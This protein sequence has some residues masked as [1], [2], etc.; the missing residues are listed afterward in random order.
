MEVGLNFTV[1]CR[2]ADTSFYSL[3]PTTE[4]IKFEALSTYSPSC[5]TAG[6]NLL[7]INSVNSYSTDL[8]EEEWG[9]T[10]DIDRPYSST[11]G[12]EAYNNDFPGKTT[13]SLWY[14][15]Q[16]WGNRAV[17]VIS[18][19]WYDASTAGVNDRYLITRQPSADALRDWTCNNLRFASK[20]GSGASAVLSFSWP[21][22][23][24]YF[25]YC[26]G[27]DI[28]INLVPC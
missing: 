1:S 21:F 2:E 16:R 6:L 4:D 7:S 23:D 11:E 26:S 14:A 28:P 20:T 9:V 18:G 3:S 12:E 8:T 22:N 13:F 10:I 27:T 15:A 19:V 17:P 24:L 25:G 5:N